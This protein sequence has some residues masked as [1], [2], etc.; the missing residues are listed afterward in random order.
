MRRQ[1]SASKVKQ[2]MWHYFDI[3]FVLVCGDTET[4]TEIYGHM[5]L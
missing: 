2:G 5:K 3:P 1:Q 4:A